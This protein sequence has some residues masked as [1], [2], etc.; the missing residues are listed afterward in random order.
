MNNSFVPVSP[1]CLIYFRYRASISGPRDA[2]ARP[3]IRETRASIKVPDSITKR[4]FNRPTKNDFH[5]AHSRVSSSRNRE[6][7][8]YIDR[9]AM[10]KRTRRVLVS[11]WEVTKKRKKKERRNEEREY[12]RI[13]EAC[14]KT[15]NAMCI[16]D[17]TNRGCIFFLRP[18][19]SS[20]LML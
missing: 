8:L 9:C 14:V 12:G 3:Q 1:Q 19:L 2:W 4:H 18:F 20:T 10:R 6:F 16:N 15:G 5:R 7:S 13:R 17:R 11:P